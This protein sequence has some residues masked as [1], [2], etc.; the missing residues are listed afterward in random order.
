MAPKPLSL[1]SPSMGVAKQALQQDLEYSAWANRRLLE[2]CST[3]TDAERTRDLGQSHSSV[4]T[5]LH[6]IYESERFWADCL[7]ANEMPPMQDIGTSDAPPELRLEELENAWPD[8]WNSLDR[9][10]ASL[11]EEEL[12]QTLRCQLSAESEFHFARWQLLRHSVN[13]STLHRG[14]IVGMLR[15]LGKQPPNVDLLTFIQ[16]P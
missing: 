4:L 7:Q 9:W 11:S 6:H 5:T 1:Y 13:H 2:A 12:A 3:L 14:Q 16:L 10:L 15:A 8:V